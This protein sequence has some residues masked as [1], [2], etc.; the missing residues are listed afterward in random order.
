MKKEYFVCDLCERTADEET[1]I[2]GVRADHDRRSE[3]QLYSDP[4]H[5]TKHTC[6][7]CVDAFEVFIKNQ[8]EDVKI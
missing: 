6:K 8:N 4:R 1:V 3:F 2:L 5:T 7:D